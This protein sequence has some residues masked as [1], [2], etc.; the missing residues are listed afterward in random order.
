MG[1]GEIDHRL[2]QFFDGLSNGIRLSIVKELL[3]DRCYVSELAN[4]LSRSVTSVSR[5]LRVLADNDIVQSETEGRKR[6]F[7]LKRPKLIDRALQLRSFF[8]R[9]N[10]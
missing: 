6:Y 1:M 3:G 2:S 5:H 10:K 4:R 8:E 9:E 7:F